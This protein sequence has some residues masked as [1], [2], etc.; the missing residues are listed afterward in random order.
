MAGFFFIS[1]I[2]ALLIITGSNVGLDSLGVSSVVYYNK[3][4]L[5]TH[6]HLPLTKM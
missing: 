4:I 2:F 3:S 1:N 6:S 5:Y